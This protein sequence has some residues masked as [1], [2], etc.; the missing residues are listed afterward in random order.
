MV[1]LLG[2]VTKVRLKQLSKADCPMLVT[3][4]GISTDFRFEQPLKASRPMLV[5][6]LGI[7]REVRPEQPRFL[8]MLDNQPNAYIKVE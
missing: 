7:A 1:T 3:L 2:M 6:L 8:L 5:T 4:L